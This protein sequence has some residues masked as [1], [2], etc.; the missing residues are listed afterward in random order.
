MHACALYFHK[1]IKGGS[2]CFDTWLKAALRNSYSKAALVRI[3]I[4]LTDAFA[5]LFYGQ[6]GRH[7][8]VM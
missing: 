7:S 6:C 1:E 3:L 2:G 8:N 5:S 4:L